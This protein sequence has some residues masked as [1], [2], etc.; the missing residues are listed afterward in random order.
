MKKF[1]TII[2]G[3][4]LVL[5]AGGI[6]W[7]TQKPVSQKL[8]IKISV[9][10]WPQTET[11]GYSAE[12]RKIKAYTFGAGEKIIAFVGGIHG[13][14]E[15]NSVMLAYEFIDYFTDQ[16]QKI[17]DGLSVKIIPVANPDGLAKIVGTSSKF[18]L[19]DVKKTTK[20]GEGRFNA[21]EVDLN[22]NFSCRWQPKSTWRGQEVS[23]GT[24]AFSEPEARAIKN[25]VL[26]NQIKAVIFWHSQS[27]AVYASECGKGVLPE[28][29]EIMNIY[30]KAAG[31]PAIETFDAYPVTGDAESWLASINIPA[32]TVEL[33]THETIEW[34]KNLSGVRALLDYYSN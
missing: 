23:A 34:E 22:R 16:P 21:N 18:A 26:E 14:Y 32:L 20:I 25:F 12:G 5:V 33:A 19:T 2:V 9:P 15:W 30:A 29:R 31:Y 24:S 17:P 27:N 13:G 11:I 8:P 10:S 6:W 3:V 1:I 28:T 7:W 4:V